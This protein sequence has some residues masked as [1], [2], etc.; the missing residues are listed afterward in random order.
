MQYLLQGDS[1]LTT[2]AK[3]NSNITPYILSCDE[4][5]L[6]LIVDKIVVCEIP[7]YLDVPF[8][9]MSAY[10]VFNI[11]YPR[12]CNNLFSFME[13]LTLNYPSEKASP[14]VKH[15]LSSLANVR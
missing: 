1:N 3:Q 7:N 12:G 2:A 13:I 6:Y 11:C 9:L 4:E 15:F 8:V 10:F 14:T 5:E